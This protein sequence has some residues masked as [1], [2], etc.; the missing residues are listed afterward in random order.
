MK[1]NSSIKYIC[2]LTPS[3]QKEVTEEL[4]LVFKRVKTKPVPM[5][6]K[7]TKKA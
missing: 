2:D 6:C 5:V 1:N 4:A 3:Q 7:P